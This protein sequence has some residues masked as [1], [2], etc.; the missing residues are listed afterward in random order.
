MHI[1][2]LT[3]NPTSLGLQYYV[4]AM[5]IVGMIY[6]LEN[7]DKKKLYVFRTDMVFWSIFVLTGCICG[8]ATVDMKGQLYVQ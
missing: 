7:N 1:L 5:K 8:C 4:N 2:L 6:Y 3:Q